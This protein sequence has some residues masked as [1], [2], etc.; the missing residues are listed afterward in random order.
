MV[1]YLEG[2]NCAFCT[3]AFDTT[4]NTVIFGYYLQF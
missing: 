1:S 4:K 2:Q 3:T